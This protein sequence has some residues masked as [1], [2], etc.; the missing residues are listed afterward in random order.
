MVFPL[1]PHILQFPDPARAD[2]DGL[3]AI[4]GDLSPERLTLAYRSGI[5]P[6]YNEGE[7]ILWYAPKERCVL[8]PGNIKVYKS[9]EQVIRKHIFRIT[10]DQA[11]GDVISHCAAAPRKGQDGTW[12]TNDMQRAY[13]RLHE[14]GI[15]HS[16]EVW[17]DG[18]LVGGLYGIGMGHVFCGESM[19]S[20]R[21][22]ASKAALIWLCRNA[23]FELIDCQ[24]PN[25]HLMSMG[26]VMINREQFLGILSA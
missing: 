23:G 6:W 3:L 5:F 25:P 4:G 22:N 11:F 24:L 10:M 18:L 2:D 8:Y 19:F 12:I 17:Q 20:H 21:S 15:A 26:A 16:V 7:P 1:S 13:L 14:F 9:M